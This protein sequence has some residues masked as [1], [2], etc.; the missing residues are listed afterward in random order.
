M[1]AHLYVDLH[2]ISSIGW[3]NA[4]KSLGYVI[5]T[6]KAYQLQEAIS[7]GLASQSSPTADHAKRGGPPPGRSPASLSLS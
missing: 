6:G 2:E 1:K 4:Q 7:W 3:A 5:V